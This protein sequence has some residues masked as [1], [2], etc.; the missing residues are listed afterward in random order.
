MTVQFCEAWCVELGEVV[1]VESANRHA[2]SVFPP[3]KLT[4]RCKDDNCREGTNP[5]VL[6]VHIG[7]VLPEHGASRSRHF[8]L[9][10]G[11]VHDVACGVAKQAPRAT[12]QREATKIGSDNSK[13]SDVV[14]IFVPRSG[15]GPPVRAA[16]AGG[17]LNAASTAAGI[18]EP[19]RGPASGLTTEYRV[20]RLW[21]QHA[22]LETRQRRSSAFVQVGTN[23]FSYQDFFLTLEDVRPVQADRVCVVFGAARYF[24][25][26]DR[27]E[28]VLQFY[29][30]LTQFAP[31]GDA[32]A[33]AR[34]LAVRLPINRLQRSAAGVDLLTLLSVQGPSRA[35]Y[36]R[37]AVFGS[38]RPSLHQGYE[39]AADSLF[40]VALLACQNKPE[41]SIGKGRLDG[42]GARR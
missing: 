28:F 11:H 31:V 7:V 19:P 22:A 18:G 6:G 36:F 20:A 12:G 24:R 9:K 27:P 42:G 2:R 41:A 8:R 29:E 30:P 23:R 39:L 15:D 5:I 21:Q 17:S 25:S 38:I 3:L 37:V 1:S 26:A 10:A 33:F 35:H 4:F 34:G 32:S 40:D 13:Q 16:D 14:D